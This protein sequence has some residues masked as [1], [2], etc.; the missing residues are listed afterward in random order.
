MSVKSRNKRVT[1]VLALIVGAASLLNTASVNEAYARSKRSSRA[2]IVTGDVAELGVQT[3]VTPAPGEKVPRWV[4]YDQGGMYYYT[5]NEIEKARN[6]FLSALKEAEVV[7]PME[8]AK[9]LK[10][11]TVMYCCNLINHLL[12][13]VSDK[14]FK[15]KEITLN[16]SAYTSTARFQYDSGANT[17]K[18][19][20]RDS[21]WLDRV[22]NFANRALG[23]EHRCLWQIN[24]KRK[25]LDILNQNTKW[26]MTLLEQQLNIG[27]SSIDRRP[28]NN[29]TNPGTVLQPNGEYLPPGGSATSGGGSY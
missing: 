9:G 10:D 17:L 28:L 21:E 1:Q 20:R 12:F 18:G 6:Y 7:V 27:Q 22:E 8:R 16:P 23:R 3:E 2:P 5:H 29:G 4:Q 26:Q 11:K 24:D 19:I 14:R 25:Q 13:F 15:P